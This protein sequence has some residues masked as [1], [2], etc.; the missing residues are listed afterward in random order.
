MSAPTV[1]V[2]GCE[3]KFEPPCPSALPT[4]PYLGN[5][6]SQATTREGNL[7]FFNKRAEDWWRFREELNPDQQFGCAISLPPGQELKADLAAPPWM[8]T[9]RGIKVEEKSEIMKQLG[10][11]ID[12]GDAVVLAMNE[13]SKAAAKQMREDRGGRRPQRANVGRS[14]FKQ[15]FRQ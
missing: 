13:G 14:E 4:A 6:P 11:S 8:L 12:D 1:I 9:P 10:R 7:K 2:E 3:P 15:G 5:K